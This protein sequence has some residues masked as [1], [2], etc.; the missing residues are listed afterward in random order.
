MPAVT[1][2]SVDPSAGHCYP[3]RPPD[4]GSANVITNGQ[5]QT[6]IG[7][8]YPAHTCGN[9]THDGAAA[10]GSPTV[11]VNGQPIHRIGDAISCGDVS[12]SGSPN[13]FAGDGPFPVFALVEEGVYLVG[14]NYVYENTPVAQAKSDVREEVASPG[15]S[16]EPD[17]VPVEP[18]APIACDKFPEIITVR[19]TSLP[20]SKYFKLSH[21]GGIPVAQRGLTA[22]QICCNWAALCTNILDPVYDAFKFSINS[23][24]RPVSGGKGGTDHGLGCAADLGTGNVQKT[25]D[26]FKW[27]VKSGLPFTQVIYER[28]GTTGTGW[29]HVS[30]NTKPR[31]AARTM[32]TYNNGATFIHGGANGENLPPLLS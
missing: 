1:R 8:H 26:M 23:G 24:W 28:N 11:I 14:G 9:S 25:I 6:K 20:V 15:M 17:P 21:C 30:F 29:V 32:Y 18:S 16:K 5:P 31:G 3:P 2:K 22:A 12:A 4:S 13:V 7:D 10:A 27:I 19:E